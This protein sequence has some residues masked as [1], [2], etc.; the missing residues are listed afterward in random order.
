VHDAL[1]INDVHEGCHSADPTTAI[2][3]RATGICRPPSAGPAS[4]DP[5]ITSLSAWQALL[6]GRLHV[7]EPNLPPQ[8][9]ICRHGE[10]LLPET[11]LTAACAAAMPA[12]WIR[13]PHACTH[14]ACYL[15]AARSPRGS[16]CSPRN[17][18]DERSARQ[19]RTPGGHPAR[20]VAGAH[21]ICMRTMTPYRVAASR[22]RCIMLSRTFIVLHVDLE[23][24]IATL[25]PAGVTQVSSALRTQPAANGR[26]THGIF[27]SRPASKARTAC[28]GTA[29]A[30]ARGP[31]RTRRTMPRPPAPL[32]AMRRCRRRRRRRR[33]RAAGVRSQLR[34]AAAHR[35]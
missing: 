25:T 12:D 23:H 7:G 27:Y 9:V 15:I 30:S 10:A 32:P 19:R 3:H 28:S 5:A 4:R 18:A 21:G 1:V 22:P 16:Q 6:S 26:N 13:T 29:S 34:A 8:Q 24:A 17:G 20:P 14:R 35:S 11:A 31:A 2:M 33:A